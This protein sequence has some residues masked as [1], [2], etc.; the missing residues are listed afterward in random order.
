MVSV[1]HFALWRAK[2]HYCLCDLHE[3]LVRRFLGT[4]CRFVGARHACRVRAIAFDRHSCI[5]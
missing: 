1:A 5:Y 4:H 3:T 2:H